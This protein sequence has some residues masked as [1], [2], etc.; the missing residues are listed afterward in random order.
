[1]FRSFTNLISHIFRRKTGAFAKLSSD[2]PEKEKGYRLRETDLRLNRT[3]SLGS[4]LDFGFSGGRPAQQQQSAQQDQPEVTSFVQ[5]VETKGRS[6]LTYRD[7]RL[8]GFNG[9]RYDAELLIAQGLPQYERDVASDVTLHKPVAAPIKEKLPRDER[10]SSSVTDLTV[11]V[12]SLRNT[13]SRLRARCERGRIISDCSSSGIS[14]DTS[15]SSSGSDRDSG[16]EMSSSNDHMTLERGVQRMNLSN[17]SSALTIAGA[18][19]KMTSSPAIATKKPLYSVTPPNLASTHVKLTL[20]M[21]R[22]PVLD[23]VI[24][25]GKAMPDSSSPSKKDSSSHGFRQPDYEVIRMEGVEGGSG[26]ASNDV[27]DVYEYE[28]PEVSFSL[29][30]AEKSTKDD[31]GRR[32]RRGKRRNSKHVFEV[33]SVDENLSNSTSTIGPKKKRLRLVLGSET[34]STIDLNN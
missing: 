14:D 10:A 27:I 3:K 13:P 24:A 30:T 17:S 28:D 31:G 34:V 12:R 19:A 26:M 22:S 25:C 7:L 6:P 29:P 4:N 2:S 1:M 8:Q 21:K 20:R 32:R 9:T 5:K 16:I 23:E 15:S 18:G 11:T 33:S